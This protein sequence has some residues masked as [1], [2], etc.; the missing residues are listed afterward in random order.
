MSA[1]PEAL[2][3]L[4]DLAT[5]SPRTRATALARGARLLSELTWDERRALA[6]QVADK[7][8]PHLVPVIESETGLDLTDQQIPAVLQMAR[9]LDADQVEELKAAILDDDRRSELAASVAD[10]VAR[11][12]GL[13]PPELTEEEGLPLVPPPPAPV[14]AD[15]QPVVA[16][17][18][19]EPAP[20]LDEHEPE[21]AAAPDDVAETSVPEPEPVEA[22]EAHDV[23]VTPVPVRPE[24]PAPPSSSD[25]TRVLER[26]RRAGSTLDRRRILDGAD[27]GDLRALGASRRRELARAFPD[28]WQRRRAIH[29]LLEVEAVEPDEAVALA[30]TV[31][32]TASRTWVVGSMSAA[33]LLDPAEVTRLLEPRAAAR[34]NARRGS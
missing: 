18:D 26:A 21:L 29:R 10:E 4:G 23:V 15:E 8:A 33:G 16:F 14:T 17:P 13:A 1:L 20:V 28:G 3:L 30:R 9:Q 12:L 25:D 31:V 34:V 22:V 6:V 5:G 27:A 19:P 2:D 24:P 32:D 7:V 11:D